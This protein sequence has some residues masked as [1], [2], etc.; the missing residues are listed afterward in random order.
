[1][2]A[3]DGEDY[4]GLAVLLRKAKLARLVDGIF[5]AEYEQSLFSFVSDFPGWA[6]GRQR[7]AYEIVSTS[8]TAHTMLRDC[9]GRCARL[10]G[11]APIVMCR[12]EGD[13]REDEC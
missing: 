5:I 1:M 3:P 13:E 8:M 7:L 4:R 10:D 9:A 11:L 12:S 6:T 2:L